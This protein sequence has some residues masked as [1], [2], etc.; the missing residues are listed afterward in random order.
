MSL[1]FAI[2]GILNVMPMTGYDLK[3][4]AF[5]ASVRHFWPADQ[6]QIYRTLSKLADD[7][8]VS[9]TVEAQDERPDRKVYAITPAGQ[10]ALTAWL[11]ADQ[12]VPT[13]RDPL[14]VQLF[15]GQ[16][17][18]RADLLRVVAQQLAA[19][20]AQLAVFDQIPIPPAASRPDDRWLALQHLTL[21]FGVAL[22]QAYVSWLAKCQEVITHMPD[23]DEVPDFRERFNPPTG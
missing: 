5:D 10:A 14:L 13:L 6:S 3:H 9:V 17:L 11:K 19:H 8:L 12:A 2:L 18:P 16:E 1:K 4:Q 23:A 21:D 7:D 15:F 22:E 20:Q